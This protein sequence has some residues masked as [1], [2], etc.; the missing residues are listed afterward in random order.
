MIQIV[1]IQKRFSSY[2][3]VNNFTLLKFVWIWL[4]TC[5]SAIYQLDHELLY[6]YVYG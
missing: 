3:I 1:I 4:T 2:V 5:I 6:I